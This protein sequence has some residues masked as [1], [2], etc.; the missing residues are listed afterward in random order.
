MDHLYKTLEKMKPMEDTYRGHTPC[1][2]S[3]EAKGIVFWREEH[4][5]CSR[6]LSGLAGHSGLPETL[7]P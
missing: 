6:L 4:S 7:H 5:A 2:Y 1:F 3:L